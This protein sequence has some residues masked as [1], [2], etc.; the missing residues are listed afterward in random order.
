LPILSRF[1]SSEDRI[2]FG[3]NK[4]GGPLPE[5]EVIEQTEPDDSNPGQIDGSGRTN[6]GVFGA[7]SP[8]T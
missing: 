3:A 2:T 7:Q 8:A 6:G 5:Q 4:G 1:W